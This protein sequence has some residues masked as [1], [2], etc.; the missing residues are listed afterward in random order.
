MIVSLHPH[1]RGDFGQSLS[2]KTLFSDQTSGFLKQARAIVVP[3]SIQAREYAF[4][5]EFTP[6][7]FPDYSCRFG[8]EGK[9]G[10]FQLLKQFNLPHPSTFQYE[11]VKDWQD[12]HPANQNLPLPYPFVIKNDEGGCG[13]GIFLI[14]S[15]QDL[16]LALNFLRSQEEKSSGGFVIQEYVDHGGKDLRVVLLGD[17]FLTYWRRQD[18]PG[19][20]RNNVGRGA[21]IDPDGDPGLT[22]TGVEVV[23]DLKKRTGI[24]LAAIDVMFDKIAQQPLITEINFVFGRKGIGG[25]IAFRQLFNQATR[26]WLQTK[27]LN[28]PI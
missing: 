19:E 28:P 26:D 17:Q 4:C 3:Q 27:G 20:F 24:N 10:N 9:A 22:S 5:Q 2:L 8:Y 23:L 21:S 1:F 25:T 12:R 16:S 11:S 6:H 15:S 18:N 14:N 13:F 7:I